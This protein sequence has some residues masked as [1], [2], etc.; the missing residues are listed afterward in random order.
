MKKLVI[1]AITFTLALIPHLVYPQSA[2]ATG[3]GLSLYYKSDPSWTRPPAAFTTSTCHT[4]VGNINF[5]W[6]G[7]APGG[8]CGVDNF[9][10]YGV[11][12]ILAP[13]TGTVTFCEQTDDQFYLTINSNIIIDDN[14]AKPAATG[15]SCNG[16]GTMNMVAGTSYPIET[17]MHEQG[18]GAEWRLLWSYSGQS[19]YVIV[20]VSNLSPTTFTVADTTPPV[21][22]SSSSFSIAENV[23]SSATAA[24]IRVSESA[25]ITISSGVDAALFNIF[26][27][28]STTALIKFKVSPNFEVPTDN[29]SN[30][31][32][33]LTLAAIDGSAN[34]ANQAITITVTD[35]ADVLLF[36]LFSL[37][38]GTK[39]A[40]FRT[41]ITIT[42]NLTVPSVVTFRSNGKVLPG[43]V[44]KPT[45]GSAP[46]IVSTCSWRPSNRGAVSLTATATAIDIGIPNATA[47][48]MIIQVLNRTGPR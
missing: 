46:N 20:P 48:P 34:L 4:A 11:G 26:F 42:V 22:T 3:T 19:S 37:P 30:N 8:S 28:D 7:G 38:G 36:N 12:F 47:N 14:T 16:T 29:G 40:T 39:L 13:V 35:V 23:S 43:C 9:T 21:F 32:Y 31:V 1:S 27:S 18:G 6:G 41:A 45:I 25:T 10:G 17:W 44:R 24:T 33:N 5:N 2:S 15:Q